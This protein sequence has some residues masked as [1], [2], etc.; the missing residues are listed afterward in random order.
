MKLFILGLILI[1]VV[2]F[3]A[4]RKKIQENMTGVENSYKQESSALYSALAKAGDPDATS[5]PAG[6]S[7]TTDFIKIQ[8]DLTT[9]NNYRKIRDAKFE[10][11]K[12]DLS[13]PKGDVSDK[14]NSC[15]QITKCSQLSDGD[16]GYC[17]YTKEFKY[18]GSGG[19]AADVCPSNAWT[20]NPNKCEEKREKAICKEVKSC[21]DLTGEAAELCAWCPTSGKAMPF[22]KVGNKKVPKYPDDICN[23]A[24]YGILDAK[25]CQQF[26]KDHPCLTPTAFSGP[27]SP[28]CLSQLWKKAIGKDRRTIDWMKY[29]KN[30]YWNTRGYPA[31]LSDM[32]A[33][34]AYTRSSDYATAVKGGLMCYGK[35]PDPCN[36]QFKPKPKE[37][38]DQL[39]KEGGGQTS[40][41]GLPSKAGVYQSG[42]SPYKNTIG[43]YQY[44]LDQA[45]E[46]CRKEGARLCQKS[47]IMDKNIC[48]AGWTADG[49]RGYPMVDGSVYSG[50]GGSRKGWRTWSTNPNSRGSAHCCYQF[51]TD[52][53]KKTIIDTTKVLA[54]KAISG[55]ATQQAGLMKMVYG[56]NWTPPPAPKPGDLVQLN[57]KE[58]SISAWHRGYII[59]KMGEK[60]SIMWTD[61]KGKWTQ[62]RYKLKNDPAGLKT[63]RYWFGWPGIRPQALAATPNVDAGGLVLVNHLKVIKRCSNA[64]SNCGLNC[65]RIIRDLL[66]RF[67]SPQDC[68]VSD[69]SGW[70]SCSK[71]CGEGIQSRSRSVKYP[72]KHNGLS[73][74]P[75][76][77]KRTCETKPCYPANYK[78]CWRDCKGGRDLPTFVGDMSKQQCADEARRRNSKYYGL[79]YQNGVGGGSRDRAQCFLGGPLYGRQG[80]RDN[81]KNLGAQ[82]NIPYGQSCSNAV[83]ENENYKENKWCKRASNGQ[84]WCWQDPASLKTHPGMSGNELCGRPKGYSGTY[85]SLYYAPQSVKNELFPGYSINQA[86]CATNYYTN[87]KNINGWNKSNCWTPASRWGRKSPA[88]IARCTNLENYKWKKGYACAGTTIRDIPGVRDKNTCISKCEQDRSCQCV[89]WMIN[90]T[91]KCRIETGPATNRGS[92]A[93]YEAIDLPKKNLSLRDVNVTARNLELCEG[94]CD[95]DS[96]CKYGLKCFQRNGYTSVPGCKGRGRKDW[97]YCIKK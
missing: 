30:G 39:W 76:T 19:P 73:C 63:Q 22:K 64:P 94:D 17:V 77:E 68:V 8:N 40:G 11:V 55:N 70:S 5:V 81:C 38:M 80:T 51:N 92:S 69:W 59:Q 65:K 44:T 29:S 57:W 90:N 25:E 16:C 20:N 75:L 79:Q 74:P 53:S 87:G 32:K 71:K 12:V 49:I 27:H 31:V 91:N 4:Y 67:P 15:K 43:G 58:G 50:C 18:G 54:D 97:D 61:Y 47:E 62:D 1:A 2:T 33:W 88:N 78:G 13:I 72:P 84:V 93:P 35:K 7:A 46:A 9:D 14:M 56:K 48:N 89:T 85:Y 10:N 66:E 95:R 28:A 60:C 34:K 24:G 52:N 36:T 6:K 86:D 45:K 82:K 3:F 96:D 23:N 37:C 83:Y 21:G 41:A 42:E 26:L